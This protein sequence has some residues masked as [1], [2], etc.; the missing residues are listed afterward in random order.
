MAL[1]QG[2][3]AYLHVHPEGEPG[4]GKTK[5]G[6]GITFFA[7]APSPGAYRLY[8]DFKHDGEVRTAEFTVYAGGAGAPAQEPGPDHDDRPHTH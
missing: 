4:D 7:E 6:P 5:P 3:L 1:R 2:D 8:L